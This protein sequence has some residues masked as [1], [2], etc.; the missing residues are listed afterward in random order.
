MA[1][2]ML[3]VGTTSL[4]DD[5]KPPPVATAMPGRTPTAAAV[6]TA[7]PATAKLEVRTIAAILASPLDEVE[8]L[9]GEGFAVVVSEDGP[10]GH[11]RG[12]LIGSG[13]SRAPGQDGRNDGW[14]FGGIGNI[15]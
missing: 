15:R 5:N 7:R 9:I 11:N 3:A 6:A 10:S 4:L 8:N 12:L 1:I 2:G 14:L 13:A